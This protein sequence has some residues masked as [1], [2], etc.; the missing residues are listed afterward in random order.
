MKTRF[1]GLGVVSALFFFG[2][3]R[4]SF[5]GRPGIKPAGGPTKGD[6]GV[7]PYSAFGIDLY[8]KL[9]AAAPEKNVFISPASIGLALAMTWNGS[10]GETQA[11]IAATLRLPA[12]DFAVVN[13]A[14]ARLISGME[15]E[16][17]DVELNVANS[18]WARKG[19]EFK[20]SFLAR[21]KRFYRAEV[22]T[23]D[24]EN[25]SSPK[26][27]NGWV[28][29]KTRDKIREIVDRLD[30]LSILYLINAIYFK[31]AWAVEF[32]PKSTREETFHGASGGKKIRMMYRSGE[33][34]YREDKDGQAIRLPYGDGQIAM[35][36]F[37]PARDSTLA[38]FY[39][40][41]TAMSWKRWLEEFAKR[42]GSLG[43]PRFTIQYE[44][45]LRQPLTELGMGV[46][47]DRTRADFSNMLTTPPGIRAYIHD[48]IHKTFCEV[49][50]EG[51]EAAAVTGVE[52]RVTSVAKP[53]KRFEMICDRPFFFAI[54]DDE[55][56]LILFMGSFVNPSS[57]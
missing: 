13:E 46:A 38:E 16:R 19:I 14:D 1:A 23:L 33:F 34:S 53:P 18:L 50:E 49:N 21:N 54:V 35:Y 6:E 31:G 26:V 10:A 41:L 43:L 47:F 37:L 56:G 2:L 48:V 9:A 24:F 29:A 51:T 52:V 12:S 57:S 55:T 15:A 28:A 32:D 45:R 7:A 25:P 4:A 11:A 3:V 39:S 20:E 30:P 40:K 22:R 44:T 42:E 36:I 27:I 17:K 8:L 5:D